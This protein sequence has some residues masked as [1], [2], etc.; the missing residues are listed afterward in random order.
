MDKEELLK[1]IKKI[2]KQI[3]NFAKAAGY[4]NTRFDHFARIGARLT[5]R[6]LAFNI[7]MVMIVFW[8]ITG[9]IF[10]FSDTWQLVINTTTTIV[11]F[12]MVFLLQHSQNRDT[13][14]LQVKIDELIRTIDGAN[15]SLLDLEEMEE[16]ELTV[17][18]NQYIELAKL[19]RNENL[20]K[21]GQG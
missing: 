8:I 10:G 1:L 4:S 18:R 7:A 14:A 19:A 11:T 16:H 15:K 20:K 13:E 17:L 21:A 9:P 5:G 2:N 3:F 12:L 6:P